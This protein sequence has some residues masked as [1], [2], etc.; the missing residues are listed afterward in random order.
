MK[1]LLYENRVKPKYISVIAILMLA[2]RHELYILN[3]TLIT[4]H[5]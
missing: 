5:R 4:L 1:T 3:I 2:E